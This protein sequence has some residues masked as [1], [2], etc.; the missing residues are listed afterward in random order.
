MAATLTD[1]IFKCIFLSENIY[2]SI[3][4][5]LKFTPKGPINNIPASLQIMAWRLPGDRPLS[6]RMMA[7]LLTHICVTSLNELE[8]DTVYVTESAYQAFL[9]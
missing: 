3:K 5:S 2:F 6:E 7:S 4:I 9:R 1:D 8:D